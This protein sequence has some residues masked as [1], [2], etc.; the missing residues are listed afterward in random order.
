M[1]IGFSVLL[2]E[3]PHYI[4][5]SKETWNSRIIDTIVLA[6]VNSLD[7]HVGCKSM[8]LHFMIAWTR[9]TKKV[10]LLIFQNILDGAVI[11]D[12]HLTDKIF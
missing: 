5:N 6:Y 9:V 12:K 10:S 11:Q 3:L 8:L 1:Q 7:L 2:S 4:K